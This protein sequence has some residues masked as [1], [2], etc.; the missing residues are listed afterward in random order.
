M[1][2]A[3]CGHCG[4]SGTKIA[5][6]SPSGAEYK[7]IA[8]CCLSCSAVLGVTGYYDTSS[9]IKKQTAQI[10]QLQNSVAEL[11]GEMGRISASLRD[12][13]RRIS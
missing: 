13:A 10:A 11:H 7:Q 12:L 1:S 2:F 6:L 5:E 8:I 3:K 4:K 9:L